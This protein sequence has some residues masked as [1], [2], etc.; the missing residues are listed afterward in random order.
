MKIVS[1]SAESVFP[2]PKEKLLRVV[3]APGLI[4]NWHPWIESITISE[5]Q[6]LVCRRARL[7]GGETELVEKFWNEE[8]ANEFHFQAVQGFWAD[9]RYRSKI[10]VEEVEGGC[11]VTWQGRLMMEEPEDEEEQMKNFYREG[12][13]GLGELLKEI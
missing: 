8:G 4:V 6:G 2:Y 11:K 13:R 12:L 1:A 10:L 5:M 3:G 7:A 9:Y